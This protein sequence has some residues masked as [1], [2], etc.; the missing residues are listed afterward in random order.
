MGLMSCLSL[1][2][3]SIRSYPVRGP[4]VHSHSIYDHDLMET[5]SGFVAHLL[6]YL[7]Q[8]YGEGT[9][10]F[11]ITFFPGSN[12][13]GP[14]AWTNLLYESLMDGPSPMKNL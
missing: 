1:A 12:G 2:T 9:R 11:V 14:V 13:L 3:L 5:A 10:L 8:D 6:M 4:V 7:E